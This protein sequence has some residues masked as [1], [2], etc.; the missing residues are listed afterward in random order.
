MPR[1]RR[2][3]VLMK[4]REPPLLC[5]DLFDTSQ[6]VFSVS[7]ERKIT[8]TTRTYTQLM[9]IILQDSSLLFYLRE[10]TN[11][12]TACWLLGWN[13]AKTALRLAFRPLAN[14]NNNNY[15][16][17]DQFCINVIWAHEQFGRPLQPNAKTQ[18]V[19]LLGWSN[20]RDTQIN[21]ILFREKSWSE[22]KLSRLDC[23]IKLQKKE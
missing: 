14:N 7:L 16:S 9:I 6:R 18:L 17:N 4:L 3:H 19:S 22:M 2:R 1:R 5:T 21:L 20:T 8:T 10:R 23:I 15:N 12:C 13:W 11:H